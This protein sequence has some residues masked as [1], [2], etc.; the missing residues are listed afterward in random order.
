MLKKHAAQESGEIPGEIR[1]T[2]TAHRPGAVPWHSYA[3]E[4][5][6]TFFMVAWG[7]SA[8]VFVMSAS[9]PMNSLVPA[10]RVRLLL[11]GWPAR[12]S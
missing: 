7:L 2:E 10:Y 3:A 1:M 4:L 12:D 5:A 11:A 9:S 6:G 8:V